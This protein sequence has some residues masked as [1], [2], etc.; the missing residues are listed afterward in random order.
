MITLNDQKSRFFDLAKTYNVIPI[1]K[2][3]VAD[4]L[5]PVMAYDRI[6]GPSSFLL[7]SVEKG[8]NVSRYSFLASDP[9]FIFSAKGSD[10]KITHADFITKT[11]GNPLDYLKKMFAKFM[12]PTLDDLPP[13][14]GGA[15]GY[16]SFDTIRYIETV[17]DRHDD[18]LGNEDIYLIFP[19]ILLAFDHV[20]HTIKIIA[21]VYLNDTINPTNELLMFKFQNAL[22]AINQ[23]EQRLDQPTTNLE[24]IEIEDRAVPIDLLQSN[25][26]PAYFRHMIQQAKSYIRAGDIFQVV[27]SQRFQQRLTD[28]PFNI[29]R[30]LRIINPSPYMFF[31]KAGALTLIGSSPE[32]LVRRHGAEALVRPIAGTCRRGKNATEDHELIQELQHNEKEKA[33]HLMLVDLGRNDLGRVCQFGSVHTS[34]FMSI[35]K[36]SHVLHMVSHVNG[37]LKPDTDAIDLLKATFPAGTL[38]GAP[39]IRAM[40]IIDE[41]E[42]TRRGIYG[43]ILGYIGFNGSMDM[44]ITIRTILVKD[45]TAYI[46]TGAGIVADSIAEDEFTETINK[47]M[48]MFKAL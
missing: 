6:Q 47:A 32:I 29:Y 40:S 21:N 33:E 38:S 13:L 26:T 37:T 46:Q 41:L 17:P 5:T 25:M 27:L 30:R 9:Q 48:G 8:E 1:Y 44:C 43:G 35:E 39:K 12:S 2:E 15:V 36:Y 18:Q 19:K 7:E 24:P 45:E 4:L 10:I 34:N 3:I 28:T 16:F 22:L 31:F 20:R 42:P 14:F 11:T 23:I